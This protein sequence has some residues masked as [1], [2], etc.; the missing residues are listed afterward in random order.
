MSKIKRLV[1]RICL[2]AAASARSSEMVGKGPAYGL[3]GNQ[4]VKA[5]IA[6][7]LI[8]TAVVAV[9]PTKAHAQVGFDGGHSQ[10]YGGYGSEAAG[11]FWSWFSSLFTPSDIVQGITTMNQ[12]PNQ[13]MANNF[14]YGLQQAELSQLGKQ[15]EH[16]S[17]GLCTGRG[18]FGPINQ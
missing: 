10:F 12:N 7:G 9:A 14:A 1:K 2:G 3:R 17:W 11:N 18:R 8:T 15:A 13:A 16:R 5:L 4:R 6:A